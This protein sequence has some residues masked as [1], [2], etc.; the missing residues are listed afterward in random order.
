MEGKP[1][2]HY[3]LGE[4]L[5]RGGMGEVYRAYDT[6]TNREVA[7]KVLP[8]GNAQDAAFQER[9]RREAHAVAGLNEPHVV[10]IHGYGEIDGQLYLDM[11]LIEGKTLGEMLADDG[12]P[13]T[14]EF[15]VQV[16]AQIGA[17]LDAA[18]AEGLIHRDVK[19]A[20]IVITDNDFAYLIDFGLARGATDAGMTTA[21]NTLGTLAYM[22]P[23][24][25]DNTVTDPRS[26]IYA[27][28]AV[29]Y[30]CLT[31]IRPYQGDSLE[32]QI[33]AHLRQPPPRPSQV[34]PRL[35]PFDDVVATGMAKQPERRYQSGAALSDAVSRAGEAVGRS[36]TGRHSAPRSGRLGRGRW[37]LA[38]AAVLVGALVAGVLLAGRSED[39]RAEPPAPT[40]A[41]AAPDG[42][43]ASL[44]AA[45]PE[46][47]KSRGTLIVGV[48]VPYA[49]DEFKND[50]GELVGFDID[51]LNAV[52]RV[53]G[54]RTEWREMAFEAITGAVG[55]GSLDVGAS[56]ITDTRARER[57]VDFVTY[58]DAGTLWARRAGGTADPGAACGLRVGVAEGALQATTELPAKSAECVAAGLDPIDKVVYPDQSEVTAAL[59]N[60]DIDALSADSTVTGFAVKLSA[61]KLEAAGSM[62]DVAPYGWPVARDSALAES[63]RQGLEH[64]I[65]TGEYREIATK[66]GVEQGVLDRPVVNG[67]TR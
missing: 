37:V 39:R 56:S 43:V 58:L 17:A 19:P 9:F 22:A 64:L 32:Q 45:V 6:R 24:R 15:C 34:N 42:R 54:L 67:A 57:S 21:G 23:E 65:A 62:T 40:V 12:R 20:N 60:G 41:P 4:R 33:A 26:D 7:L 44:A 27:L 30:E 47:I 51:L 66:W 46:P 49:P 28:T 53:L 50:E 38:G 63:L 1:F 5:G 48:N 16:V 14:P 18:H 11:R 29:L 36:G 8:P 59:L 61:G 3:R 13:L 2:G 10:P 31:G 55:D 52:A 35:A 25:F